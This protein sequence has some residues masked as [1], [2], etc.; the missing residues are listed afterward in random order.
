VL[1]RVADLR[2]PDFDPAQGKYSLEA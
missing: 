2:P 1:G